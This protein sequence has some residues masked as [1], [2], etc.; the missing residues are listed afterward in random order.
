MESKSIATSGWLESSI[1]RL[2]R[3]LATPEPPRRAADRTDRAIGLIAASYLIP[4]ARSRIADQGLSYADTTGN[5]RI[6][7]SEPA[8][9]IDSRGV[10][11]NPW[12]QPKGIRSL[13]GRATGSAIRALLDF[14]P[15][16]GIREL[17]ARAT[18]SAPTLS[19]VVDLLAQE[20]LVQRST[21]GAVIDNNW[22][23][24]LR[25]WVM[26]YSLLTTNDPS[27][28]LSPRGLDS[29]WEAL[30][31]TS[32]EYAVSGTKALPDDLQLAPSRL[33]I[34]YT[35]DQYQLAT[36]ADLRRTEEGANVLLLRPFDRVV[37]QR[38]RE[39]EG[40]RVIALSQLAAD[41]LTGPGRAPTEAEELIAWMTSNES[42]WR[43]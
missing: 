16:Y 11:K 41:L 26:D 23:G 1:A 7:A 12:P 31:S 15:P 43:V 35:T 8:I 14:R 20:Q 27:S 30:A 17:A 13:K 40:L 36:E 33:G 18:V 38:C 28:Y 22:A 32:T 6:T 5:V 39:V 37:F 10:D 21:S 34:I 29:L 3:V 19:R 2:V 9:Y 42:K 25:R 4:P 24:I